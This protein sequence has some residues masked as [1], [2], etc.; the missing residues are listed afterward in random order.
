MDRTRV[1]KLYLACLPGILLAALLFFLPSAILVS[2]QNPTQY[3]AYMF[4]FPLLGN[5]QQYGHYN[6][7]GYG[8]H[9]T[10][11]TDTT[12]CWPTVTYSD[13]YHAGT[14]WFEYADRPGIVGDA[15][16]A[17]ADGQVA[18][19]DPTYRRYPGHVVI[20][21]HTLPTGEMRYSMYGHLADDSLTVTAGSWVTRGQKI[22]EVKSWPS[23]ADNSHLHWEIRDW[24]GLTCTL[25]SLN[26]FWPGPGYTYPNHPDNYGYHDPDAFVAARRRLIEANGA[27]PN[28]FSPDNDGQN[29]TTSIGYTLK[30]FLDGTQVT[31]TIA[32]L[33]G[34][35]TLRTLG[36]QS[37]ASGTYAIP[38]DG[39]DSRGNV[40]AN[41]TYVYSITVDAA[42]SL[43]HPIDQVT[44][45]VT[46][47][48]VVP[49]PTPTP[50]VTTTVEMPVLQGS[51]DAGHDPGFNCAYSI[52][53]NEIYFGE[54]YDGRNIT[55]GFRFPN[56]PVPRGATTVEAYI[57]FTVDGPYEHPLILRLAGE[58]TGNAQPFSAISRPDNRP[59]TTA[60]ATWNILAGDRW[61]LGGTRRSPDLSAIVQ[62]IVNRADWNA[63]NALA[64]IVENAAPAANQHR[65][66]IGYERPGWYPG[67]EYGARLVIV[68]SGAP[69]PTPTPTSTRTPTPTSTPT[70]TPTPTATPTPTSTPTPTFTPTRTPTPTA[71]PPPTPTP[72]P[73]P[74]WC[75]L[76]WAARAALPKLA[77]PA[78]SALV[79]IQRAAELAPLLY[80]VR[81][82]VLSQT[83]AGQYYIDVYYMHST[84]ITDLILA[85]PALYDEGMATLELFVPGL[86]ALVD[87]Q[88][89][90]VT[91]TAEQVQRAEAFLDALAA[92]GSPALRQAIATERTRRP[93][94]QLVGMTMDQAWAH[95]NGYTLTWLPPL[96]VTN[97][98]PVR[99]GRTVPVRF[100]LTDF[101]GEFAIDSTVALRLVNEAGVTV[102]GPVGLSTNPI[103]GIVIRGHQYH[104]DMR[105]T[106]LTPGL[107]ML[108][109]DYNAVEPGQR[110]TWGINIS[111]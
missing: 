68:Y 82:E 4:N 93:L 54:C 38:W 87:G 25:V 106:G 53:S 20:I 50:P 44:S 88:G 83:E 40:V 80:R 76:G 48:T 69:L 92:V 6:N 56:V 5:P 32:I 110:A 98:Y 59:R 17:V 13:T 96:S 91:I 23:D 11:L 85:D 43:S 95:L 15:V 55:S 107:Y 108:V 57:R 79:R 49:T 34:T 74:G 47:S 37:H 77:M 104:Y 72:T 31:V 33:S 73:R 61:E 1:C 39:M 12:S 35:T 58:A 22:A 81:D 9:N 16:V 26:Y 65:R 45:T 24:C 89:E 7:N 29:D 101:Q 21:S 51:D 67:H 75:G 70:S 52:G 64:V 100:T 86:Q 28:P 105:T 66:V 10:S 14:D 2:A 46:V 84:E 3:V 60:S 41:S 102:V 30:D 94:A 18:F 71:T 19:A 78:H 63:Y 42:D 103:Q 90:A 8:V 36:P 111:R 99:A 27:V 97:P 62:E 109:I